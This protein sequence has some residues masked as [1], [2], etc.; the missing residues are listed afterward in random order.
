YANGGLVFSDKFL[1][2]SIQ[3]TRAHD[4]EQGE[5]ASLNEG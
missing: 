3:L 1:L 4:E 5:K 2:E